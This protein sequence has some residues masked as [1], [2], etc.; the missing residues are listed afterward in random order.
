MR[1]KQETA[2][3]VMF[4]T[5]DNNISFLREGN[6]TVALTTG[7]RRTCWPVAFPADSVPQINANPP[8]ATD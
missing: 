7:S 5:A 6:S 8:E 2:M 1:N 4:A 3:P